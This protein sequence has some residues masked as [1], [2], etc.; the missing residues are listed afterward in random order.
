MG[1]HNFSTSMNKL[2]LVVLIACVATVLGGFTDPSKCDFT[3]A[4][5]PQY[6][7]Y[8]LGCIATEGC[9]YIGRCISSTDV[10]VYCDSLDPA[11]GFTYRLNSNGKSLA[12]YAAES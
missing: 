10:S 12:D 5:G 3:K 4:W 9:K 1:P 11:D 8:C 7:K 2:A 6:V